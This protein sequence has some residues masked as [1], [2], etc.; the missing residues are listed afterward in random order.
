[1]KIKATSP[2]DAAVLAILDGSPAPVSD[3]APAPVTLKKSDTDPE[4]DKTDEEKEGANGGEKEE[5]AEKSEKAMKCDSTMKKSVS[6]DDLEKALTAAEAI[7]QGAAAP[8]IDRRA[9][10]AKKASESKL[11]KS[12]AEELMSLLKSAAGAI[13][14]DAD[15][16]KSFSEAALADP[17]ITAGHQSDGFDVSGFLAR[18]ASFVGGAMDVLAERIGQQLEKGFGGL[19]QYN[20]AQSKVNRALSQL[21]IDQ[22]AVIERQSELVKSLTD[23][24]DH[25]EATPVGRRTAPTA[26]ALE[27]SFGNGEQSPVAN[28]SRDQ[29]V[30]G[31]TMLQKS[32]ADGNAPCGENITWATT[33]FECGQPLSK[34]MAA[35]VKKVLS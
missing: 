31:L 24:I 6:V 12:E 5:V 14:E 33:Q 35:D 4:E 11:E 20:Q 27:K 3:P 8:A 15:L 13:D 25:V 9:E 7:A 19:S 29:I 23:R 22:G 28:V 17:D 26:R 34:S 1:M 2:A 16:S 30:R 18:N 32:S 10:L 21:V